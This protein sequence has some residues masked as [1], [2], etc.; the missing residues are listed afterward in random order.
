M[1][2]FSFHFED[3]AKITTITK[4]HLTN[5]DWNFTLSCSDGF[6][7]WTALSISALYLNESIYWSSSKWS[8]SSEKLIL[9]FG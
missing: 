3:E 8:S 9:F 4:L 2:I 5:F 1:I 7:I 6:F